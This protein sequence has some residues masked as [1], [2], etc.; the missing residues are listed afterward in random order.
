[1]GGIRFPISSAIGR[2]DWIEK[3]KSPWTADAEPADVADR[4]GLV[5]AVLAAPLLEQLRVALDL[6]ELVR[7][8][9]ANSGSPGAS[10]S[11]T[12]LTIV[13]PIRTGIAMMMRRTM[14]VPTG[15]LG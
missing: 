7:R 4:D 5:Q 1:M 13:I 10:D 9:R 12:K 14:Y 8:R 15:Q 6:L 3:P 11:A 2:R